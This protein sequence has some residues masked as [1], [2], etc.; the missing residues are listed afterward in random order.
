MLAVAVLLA[1]SVKM[2][3]NRHMT[4]I[5]ATGGK[6][7]RTDNLEPSQNDNPDTFA[8][9]DITYPPPERIDNGH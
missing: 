1:T 3:A 7:C 8:A 5:I 6:I 9:S 2:V 4:I